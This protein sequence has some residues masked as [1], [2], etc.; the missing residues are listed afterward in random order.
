ML[1]VAGLESRGPSRRQGCALGLDRPNPD[2]N[3]QEPEHSPGPVETVDYGKRAVDSR[4]FI[5]LHIGTTFTKDE[6]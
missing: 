4:A 6:R 3:R 2:D 1:S 5:L